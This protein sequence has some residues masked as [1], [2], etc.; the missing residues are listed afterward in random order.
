MAQPRFQDYYDHPEIHN[1]DRYITPY[2]FYSTP[3]Q[4]SEAAKNTISNTLAKKL[5]H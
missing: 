2:S 4:K 3:K 1:K 5:Q